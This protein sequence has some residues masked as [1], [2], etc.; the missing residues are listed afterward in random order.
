MILPPDNQEENIPVL[1]TE[2]PDQQGRIGGSKMHS[3][4]DLLI[5]PD[6][7]LI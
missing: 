2:G 4:Y 3:R 5:L 7:L 6:H 1:I